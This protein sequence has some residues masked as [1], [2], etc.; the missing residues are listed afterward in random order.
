MRSCDATCSSC[1]EVIGQIEMPSF[2]MRKGY[3]LV[4]C[5][6]AAIFD[7]PDAAGRH[8]IDHPVIERDHAIGDIFLQAIASQQPITALAGDDDRHALVLEPAKE[9]AQ[10]RAHDRMIG[11]TGEKSFD[12]VEHH[13]L[14]FD[15]I[16]RVAEPDKEPFE[17]VFAVSSNSLRST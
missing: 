5:R 16:N 2:S 1:A 3:S 7:N 11:Q 12:G 9:S 8:L 6:A 14:R 10:F 13:A 4:P 15:G 17:I